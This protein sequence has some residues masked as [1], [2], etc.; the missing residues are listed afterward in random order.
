MANL[1]TKIIIS[2]SDQASNVFDSIQKNAGKL[3]TAVA[4]YFGFKLFSASVNSAEE[5]EAAISRVAAAAGATAEELAQLKAAAE[6][7]GASTQYTSVEAAAALENLA[8]AG[9]SASDA[10]ATLPAVL[11]LATAG[12]VDLA[13]SAEFISKA[14]AGLGLS[15]QDAGRVADVLAKGANASNTSVTGLAQ[16]LSYA[17]PLANSLGLS[18]EQTVAIIGKFADAGIDASRA[19]TALNS[20]L[21]QFSDPASKFRTE[22]ASAGIVTGDFD[23]ALR[24]LAASGPAG[25]RAILAV[26]QEAGPALR[27]LLNQGIESLDGLKAKLD[28]AGGSARTFAG[29]MSSNVE[30]ASKGLASAWEALKIKLGEP[31]LGPLKDQVDSLAAG[32]RAFV[33]N[34]TATKF[35]EAIAD[36][37]RSGA[38]W[39]K[40]F[41]AQIDF[42]AVA[43]KMQS[44]AAEA[45]AFFDDFGR[46]ATNAGNIAQTA[47]GVMAAGFNT[48]LASVYKL[49]EGVSWMTSALLADLA[50]IMDGLDAITPD[51]VTEKFK[52]AATVLREESKAAAAVMQEFGKKS[53]AAFDD[54]AT[55]AETAGEGWR[56]L[57]APIE[58]AAKSTETLAESTKAAGDQAVLTADQLDA[59]GEGAQFVGGKVLEAAKEAEAAVPALKDLGDSAEDTANRL[60]HAFAALGVV[61]SEALKRQAEEARGHFET[62]RNSGRA[63]AADIGE[64][65]RAYAEKAIAANGGVADAILK[66]QAAQFGMRI[67][68]DEAGKAIVRSMKEA[69]AATSETADAADTAADNFSRMAGEADG[70]AAAIANV[71]AANNSIVG[72]AG[73]GSA[74]SRDFSSFLSRAESLGGKSAQKTAN[75]IINEGIA[76]MLEAARVG[77]NNGPSFDDIE[78]QLEAFVKNLE[79]REERERNR[80]KDRQP[81]SEDRTKAGGSSGTADTGKQRPVASSRHEVV[82]KLD[83]GRTATVG[84]AGEADSIRLIGI[85]EDLKRVSAA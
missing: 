67:E 43:A 71:A 41:I 72:S 33:S 26:G 7:A 37:F 47:Y 23:Q 78:A 44:F 42:D 3:A 22:L 31:I 65:F 48:V 35:G 68:A 61:S 32:L 80:D 5:F 69:A 60:E 39:A 54:A 74:G 15:F 57:N 64:A 12:G 40:G 8:K 55:A 13:T 83:G 14:V 24:Q 28:D 70:A 4:G 58:Q 66:A 36:A 34:G 2:A 19:G 9:L 81:V 53:A 84:M 6:E 21:A 75:D 82:I 49:G 76:A 1:V 45:S 17:A 56:A 38:E 25:Q 59:L 85:L 30:G 27:A 29:V 62:I 51:V 73:S 18:L 20:I 50:K 63:T 52:N 11:D 10:V 79:R 46:K 16:A 77:R